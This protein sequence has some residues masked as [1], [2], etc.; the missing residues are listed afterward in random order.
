MIKLE[1]RFNDGRLSNDEIVLQSD[2]HVW[3]EK[4]RCV[5]ADEIP[6]SRQL[7]KRYPIIVRSYTWDHLK[8]IREK[9]NQTIRTVYLKINL[10]LKYQISEYRP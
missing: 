8:F 3:G 7:V 10:S 4:K 5:E 2:L 6:I 1:S 9:S